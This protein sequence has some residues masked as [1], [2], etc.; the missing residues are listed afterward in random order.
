[1]PFYWFLI[2]KNTCMFYTVTIADGKGFELI[3]DI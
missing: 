3:Q 1:M 2:K